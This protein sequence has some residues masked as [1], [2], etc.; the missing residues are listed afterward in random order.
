MSDLVLRPVQRR[1]AREVTHG[2]DPNH[3]LVQA[4]LKVS[5]PD[6]QLVHVS[7]ARV[8]DQE[9][10][11][12]IILLQAVAITRMLRRDPDQLQAIVPMILKD[13]VLLQVIIRTHL[14]DLVQLQVVILINRNVQVVVHLPLLL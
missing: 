7:H 4:V 14:N 10:H 12:V 6:L 2:P 8:P 3:A 9:H 1:G 11:T 13:Q 5:D